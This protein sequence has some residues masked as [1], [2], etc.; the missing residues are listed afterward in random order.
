FL[1]ICHSRTGSNFLLW[2]LASHPRILH[3]GEP[4]GAYQLEHDWVSTRIRD[5]GSVGYLQEL[6]QR[7]GNEDAVGFKLLYQQLSPEFAE[8][9]N[10]AD[11]A[12]LR[13]FLVDLGDL[14]VI[15]LK[16]HGR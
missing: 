3:I 9:W 4:F 15:H 13:E 6:L 7:K 11:L 10:L 2:L 16:R 1:V 14:K 8:Q 12:F 5:I